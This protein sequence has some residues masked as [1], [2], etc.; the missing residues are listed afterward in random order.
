MADPPFFSR[1]NAQFEIFEFFSVLQQATEKNK[2]MAAA[3]VK[4]TSDTSESTDVNNQLIDSKQTADG[5]L[6]QEVTTEETNHAAT[7]DDAVELG[8]EASEEN[9]KEK[10]K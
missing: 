10:S 9:D 1:E 5:A 6:V 7:T 4:E 2:E 3:A 8:Q